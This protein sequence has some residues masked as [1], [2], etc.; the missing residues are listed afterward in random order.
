MIALFI[1]A[2]TVRLSIYSR[3][4][5]VEI[6]RLVGATDRFIA[7]PF[8][9][10]GFLQGIIGGGLGLLILFAA[11]LALSSGIEASTSLG[12]FFDVRFLSPGYGITIILFSAF[13]GWL[14]CYL[15]LKQFLKV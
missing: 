12:L 13:L 10:E 7:T 6:M 8:Y 3:R 4:E 9:I 11:Y 15:S 1:T 2:N 5:E 14:G